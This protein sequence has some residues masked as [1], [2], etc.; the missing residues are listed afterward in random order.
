MREDEASMKDMCCGDGNC[1][2]GGWHAGSA[3]SWN[4]RILNI[5]WILEDDIAT[6]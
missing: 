6:A 3:E 5:G 1:D 2:L 4:S